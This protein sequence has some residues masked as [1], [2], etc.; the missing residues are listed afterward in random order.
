M[1]TNYSKLFF[2]PRTWR[3]W[4]TRSAQDAVGNTVEVRV[5]SS[6]P[7]SFR[8]ILTSISVAS[9]LS[10]PDASCS[11]HSAFGFVSDFEA[12]ISDLEFSVSDDNGVSLTMDSFRGG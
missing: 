9:S 3:N 11:L 8:K 1:T 5:L 6:A 7:I 10:V 4:Q 2:F 12:G